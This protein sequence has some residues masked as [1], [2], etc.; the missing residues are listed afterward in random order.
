MELFIKLT[1]FAFIF[2]SCHAKIVSS[3]AQVGKYGYRY[4]DSPYQHKK[5]GT[6]QRG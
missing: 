5:D 2:I 3:P 4:S 6:E 1:A